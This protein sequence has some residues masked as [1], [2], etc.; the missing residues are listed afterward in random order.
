LTNKKR[1]LLVVTNHGLINDEPRTGVWFPE[2]SEPYEV[3]KNGDVEMT[4]A[5]PQGGPSP[6]DPRKFPSAEEIGKVRD[7]LEAM[8]ST[9]PLG[10]FKA[11]DFDGIFMPG[12]HGPMFDLAVDPHLKALLAD[13]STAGKPIGAVCHG[14]ASLLDVPLHEG[15]T[16]LKGKRVTGYTRGEDATDAL[17][18]FMPFALQD[19][20]TEEGAD[21]VAHEPRA[22]HVEVD[23]K[24]VTGQNPP[25]AVATAK[26]FLKVLQEG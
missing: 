6:I 19:K 24:L 12:G 17:F 23:G 1:L 9:Q 16:L 15:G 21:F 26:A 22:V 25:S 8:N 5:S 13:F 11:E 14:P 2:F 3:F 4:V 18:Q 7:A 20:M 10:K